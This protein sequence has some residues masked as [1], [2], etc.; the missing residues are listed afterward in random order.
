MRLQSNGRLVALPSNIRLGWK[1][2]EVANALAR[3]D[4]TTI[5]VKTSFIVQASIVLGKVW[6]I[7]KVVL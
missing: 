4:V 3:Y 5:T 6:V 7:T 1:C 2:V